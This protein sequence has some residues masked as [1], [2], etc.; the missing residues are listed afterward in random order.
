MFKKAFTLIELLVVIAIIGILLALG[1]SS[2]ITAQKQARD[3]K[4]KADMEQIRQAL[5]T[6]RSETGSY[7]VAASGL[8]TGLTPDYISTLPV[9]P[10]SRNYVYTRNSATTYT[11]CGAMEITPSVTACGSTSCATGV[12]CNYQLIN[13]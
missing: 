7:P 3:S 2:F 11:L 9:D 1:T 12:P 5:E 4:R 8:P 10:K 13:P 6:Y